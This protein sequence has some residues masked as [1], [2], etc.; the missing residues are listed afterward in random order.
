MIA[1]REPLRGFSL[2]ELMVVLAVITIVS[3]IVTPQIIATVNNYKLRTAASGVAGVF[4][5][6]RMQAVNDDK[7]YS[8]AM[9]TS[10]G[11]G[12]AFADLWGSP[13]TPPNNTLDPAENNMI[14]YLPRG[15]SFDTAGPSTASM[16]L[17]F[18]PITAMPSFNARG[19]PCTPSGMVCPFVPVG[20]VAQN[21]YLYYLRQDRALSRPAWAAITVSPAGRVRVWSWNGNAWN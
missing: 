3:A 1:R 8:V 12:Y 10:G 19:L 15:I 13:T 17:D 2:L 4:Q 5:K 14:T 16:N 11:I 20:G 18:A 6:A 9:G 7:W 21:G